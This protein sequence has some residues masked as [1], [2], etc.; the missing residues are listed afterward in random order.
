MFF[1]FYIDKL[2]RNPTKEN[3]HT[4]GNVHDIEYMRKKKPNMVFDGTLCHSAQ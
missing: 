2:Y 3:F 1:K 4:G